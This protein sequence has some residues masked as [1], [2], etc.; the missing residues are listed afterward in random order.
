MTDEAG[1]GDVE[2]S[3]PARPFLLQLVRLTAGVV[4]ARADLGLNDVEDL[5]LAV[6]E[7]CLSLIGP[8]GTAGRLTL[9]YRWDDAMIEISCTLTPDGDAHPG[10][11]HDSPGGASHRG[12]QGG[13]PDDLRQ[14]LSAQILDALV[15]EHGE[16]SSDGRAYAWLRTRRNRPADG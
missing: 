2:L 13:R 14:E 10:E 6:D 3:I 7:L 8:D 4:G 16:S 5:R 11:G 9:H 15:D 1:T 12:D